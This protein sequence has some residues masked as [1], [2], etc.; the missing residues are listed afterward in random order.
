MAPIKE[1]DQT[2]DDGPGGATGF[3]LS[4]DHPGKARRR[5]PENWKQF[6]PMTV[7]LLDDEWIWEPLSDTKKQGKGG[8]LKPA[9]QAAYEALLDAVVVS[10]TPGQTTKSVWLAECQRR[11]LVD[12]FERDDDGKE[13]NRKTGAFRARLT[14]LVVAKYIGIDGD[15]ISLLK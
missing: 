3:T 8:G 14:D 11:G 7:R 2:E 5:T 4:F 13:R 15:K 6:Q 12:T 1:D 10:G 9:Q